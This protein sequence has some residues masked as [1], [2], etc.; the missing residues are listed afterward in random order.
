MS[1]KRRQDRGRGERARK[2]E[3]RHEK[4]LRAGRAALLAGVVGFSLLHAV[5]LA[6]LFKPVGALLTNEPVIHQDWG[7]HF[8]HLQSLYGFWRNEGRLW[9]YNPYFMAGYPSNTI[10]DLSIKFFEFASLGLTSVGLG[11]VQS[12]KLIVFLSAA[13][14]PWMI[15]AAA[16]I[17]FDRESRGQRIAVLAM[18]LGTAAWWGS[19]PREMFFYGVFGF[20]FAS[21][22]SLLAF[23]LAHRILRD[24]TPSRTIGAAWLITIALIPSAHF[25]ATLIVA[26]PVG[27]VLVATRAS[28]RLKVWGWLAAAMVLAVALNLPWLVPAW[29]HRHD[30]VSAKLVGELPLFFS[31]DPWTFLR[32]YFTSK[33]YW[34]FRTSG[35]E[36]VFRSALLVLGWLGIVHMIRGGRRVVGIGL[37]IAVGTLFL[38]S[39][40]GSLIPVL[41]GWQ[42]LRFKVPHDFFLALAAAFFSAGE[43]PAWRSRLL[44]R[45]LLFAATLALAA[46]L[47]E[48]ES[49]K[50]L[51]LRTQMRPEMDAIVAWVRDEAPKETRLLFEE[52]GDETGFVYD[53]AYLSSFLAHRTGRQLIGGPINL[54]NDRHHFAEFHSGKLFGR[55]ILVFS[56]D[57]LRAYF[58]AYNIG[59]IVAFHPRSVYRLLNAPDLI[60][61]EKKIGRVHLM[62]VNQ[63]PDWFISGEGKIEARLNTLN[64]SEIKGD[65]MVLKFHWVRGLAADPPVE[66]VPHPVLDDPIP[67]IKI[68]RPPEKLTLGIAP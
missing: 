30:E 49:K 43:R 58:W 35:W 37:A 25:Q 60:S 32:D 34:T 55:D 42:P 13:V 20:P 2:G 56:D 40:F 46:N 10:Q 62:K 66:L 14:V 19:L 31:N 61:L 51:M 12:F 7:L 18:M 4:P 59:A 28:L 67:F 15:F 45:S 33:S 68:A 21:V 64:L 36:K 41:K 38:V 57:D 29:A 24:D 65:E 5:G 44:S 50:N 26:P 47:I 6:A 1:K 23:A 3:S 27:A 53:G 52:S 17:L 48:T 63:R 16:R 9:G 8:H 11:L 39:Y 54:Y 22:L